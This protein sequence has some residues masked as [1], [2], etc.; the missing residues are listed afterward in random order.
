MPAAS[1]EPH[2]LGDRLAPAAA[3]RGPRLVHH[4]LERARHLL[5]HGGVRQPHAGHQRERLDPAQRVRR[6]VGVHRRQR[7]VVAGVERH[8]HVERLGAAH[9]AHHDAVGPHAQRVAHELADRHLAAALEVGRPGLE[10]HH[11]GLAQPQLGGVLDRHDPLAFLQERRRA[12]RAWWSCRSRCRRRPGS[13]HAPRTQR[14]E[15]LGEL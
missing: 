6:R 9:L 2:H 5:A 11:V 10:P 12:R 8:E 14:A 4:Q 3:R 13:T 1:A 7:A 15:E